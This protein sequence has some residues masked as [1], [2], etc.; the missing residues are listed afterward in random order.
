MLVPLTTHLTH[1]TLGGE[2]EYGDP[3]MIAV[4]SLTALTHLE[5]VY[6]PSLGDEFVSE[7]GLR[8]SFLSYVFTQY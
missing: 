8:A 1:L 2:G 7:K 6:H 3:E 5:M 4:S